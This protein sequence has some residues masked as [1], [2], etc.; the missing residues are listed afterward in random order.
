MQHRVILSNPQKRR[1]TIT[2]TVQSAMIQH[3]CGFEKDHFNFYIVKETLIGQYTSNRTFFDVT[4]VFYFFDDVTY[5][6][7]TKLL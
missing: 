4:F 6:M 2:H 3:K 5:D 7:L 1:S